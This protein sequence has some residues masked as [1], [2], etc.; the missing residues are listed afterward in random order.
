[1]TSESASQVL[2]ALAQVCRVEILKDF[3]RASCIAST[4]IVIEVLRRYGIHG[5]PIAVRAHVRDMANTECDVLI[6]TDCFIPHR[7]GLWKGTAAS[8]LVAIIP[9]QRILIDASLD[10]AERYGISNLPCPFIAE[11]NLDFIAAKKQPGP[12]SH[13]P[14][15]AHFVVGKGWD[16]YDLTYW[17]C[18][19]PRRVLKTRDWSSEKWRRRAVEAICAHI[20]TS[21]NGQRSR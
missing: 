19:I 12:R 9:A 7:R 21:L 2:A 13:V 10:Q 3:G 16:Y 17:R 14:A 5:M 8:H 15:S 11:V 18:P 4:R 20:T 1:M 6:G